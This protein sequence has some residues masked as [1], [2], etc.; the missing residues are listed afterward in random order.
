MEK[1]WKQWQTIFWAP[2]S[3]QMVN[4]AMKLKDACSLEEKL[5]IN[6][7]SVLKNRDITLPTKVHI[8]KAMV[9][10]GSGRSPGEGIGNPLQYSRLENPMDRGA[11]QAKVHGIPR[12]RHNL[13]AKSPHHHV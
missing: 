7:D 3:L 12:V 11:W 8:V 1:Q 4:A 5:L 2:K 6:L 9:F 10:P 13:A